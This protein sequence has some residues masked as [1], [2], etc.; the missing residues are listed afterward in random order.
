MRIIPSKRPALRRPALALTTILVLALAAGCGSSS[1]SSDAK[2]DVVAS[3]DVWGSV[4]EHVAGDLAGSEV[5]I[6]SIITDP[7]ADPHSYEASARTQLAVSK[8]DLVVE[9]GGGY[10]D[11]VHRMLKAHQKSGVTVLDAVDISGKKASGG[12]ELNE[13][14]WYDF[15]TVAKVAD[16]VASALSKA[17]PDHRA[18]YEKNAATFRGQLEQ[19]EQTEATVKAAHAGVGV[20]ITEPVPLYLLS[21]CGLVN[22]TPADFSEAVEEGTDVSPQVLQQTL[23]LF[24][25]HRVQLLAYNEQT[26]GA[27]TESVLKAARQAGVAVVPVT[28][29]LPAHEDYLEWMRGNLAAVQKALS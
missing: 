27:E 11:F 16:R 14:V 7:S 17:D 4:V 19:L 6:T 2:V 1:S 25:G 15:P 23:A 8:A 21:A 29:T 3:T 28:E 13:H 26:S 10:D 12:A 22:Q 24:S 9:N 5:Q 18:T 20:A